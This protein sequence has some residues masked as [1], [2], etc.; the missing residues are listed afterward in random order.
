MLH[1]CC[2]DRRFCEHLVRLQKDSLVFFFT[3]GVGI[4]RNQECSNWLPLCGTAG[5]R[6]S[7]VDPRAFHTGGVE[8]HTTSGSAML[9]A[10]PPMIKTSCTA[11]KHTPWAIITFLAFSADADL[12]SSGQ[13]QADI[14][15]RMLI[16]DSHLFCI[17]QTHSRSLCTGPPAHAGGLREVDLTSPRSGSNVVTWLPWDCT[18]ACM[19]VPCHP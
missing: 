6:L 16:L 10:M 5:C 3:R 9:K 8:Y 11:P 17:N 13:L 14:W 1:H 7:V 12:P 19:H 2:F 4:Y 15:L 18:R